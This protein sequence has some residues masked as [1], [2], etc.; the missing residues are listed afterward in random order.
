MYETNFRV[1]L[2]VYEMDSQKALRMWDEK[3]FFF[4]NFKLATAV[5]LNQ[6]L[7]NS[8]TLHVRTYF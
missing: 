8:F 3:N 7:F 2:V 5:D 4:K 6:C 1:V